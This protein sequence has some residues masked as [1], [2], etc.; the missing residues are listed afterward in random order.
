MPSLAYILKPYKLH[1]IA[2]Q[3]NNE[4]FEFRLY[5]QMSP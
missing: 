3:Q 4:P 2:C 1:I 5:K